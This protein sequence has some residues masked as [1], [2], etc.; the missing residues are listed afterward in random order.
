MAS[1]KRFVNA[2]ETIVT[3]ALD[4]LLYSSGPDER[5]RLDGYPRIKVIL[6]GDWKYDKVA[7]ISGGGAGHEPAHAGFVGA[8][9]L[10]AAVSGE[11]FASPQVDAVLAGILSVTG[12]AGCLVI[13]KNYTGDRLNFGLAVERA[14]SLGKKVAMVIVSDD[15]AIPGT[16]Q[17]RGI[18]GTL[19]V[20]KIAGYL[21]EHGH[22]LEAVHAA[23]E[24]V[25]RRTYSLGISLSTC[26]VPGHPVDS[27]LAGDQAELGLGIHGEPGV[28]LIS[29]ASAREL[30]ETTLA[31]LKNSLPNPEARYALLLNNLGAVP[32][33]EMSLLAGEIMHSSLARQIDLIVGPGSFMT[34]LDMNGFSISLLELDEVS[35]A[36]L[37]APVGPSA[38]TPTRPVT[39]LGTSPLPSGLKQREFVASKDET[40]RR[41]VVTA[42]E[43]LVGLEDRLNKL[44][45]RVGDGD[46]GSTLAIGAKAI[47]RAIDDLPLADGASLCQAISDI[48]A[49]SMGGSSGV[50]LSIFLTSIGRA[51]QQTGSWPK[52]LESGIASLQIYGGAKIGDRTMI[53]ALIPASVALLA[54][55]GLAGAAKMARAGAEATAKMD[56]AGAGRSAYLSAHSLADV[57][58]PGAVAVAEV[59]AALAALESV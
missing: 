47:L 43:C 59:F 15:V 34:S 19:F 25:A 58:D 48:L 45:A 10:T 26:S 51:Y 8:G 42:A 11:I 53:D 28:E 57:P 14:K 52:A 56:R 46:T 24:R 35:V 44:D 9:M 12:D 54:G 33:I 1:G 40:M 39:P 21:A 32:A 37:L 17:P 16:K 49:G 2:G 41:R 36:G 13:V 6:R 23:A 4:G 29:M 50:L 38:W 30:M 22:S 27:R 3:D 18:A 5:V 7:V 55:N 31:R 20:H